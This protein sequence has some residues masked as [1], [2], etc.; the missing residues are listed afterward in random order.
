MAVL[1]YHKLSEIFPQHEL[2][3][4]PNGKASDYDSYDHIRRFRV[5]SPGGPTAQ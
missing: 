5:R 3:R 2:V 1:S 4:W